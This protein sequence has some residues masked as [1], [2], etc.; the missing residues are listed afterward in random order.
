MPTYMDRKRYLVVMAAGHGTRMGAELPKQFLSLSGK[1]ILHRTIQKFINA[2]PGI[3]VVTVLPPDGEHVAW[4]KNYCRENNFICPQIIVKGGI[5]RFHSV[6]AA[7]EKVPDGALVAVQDGVRPMISEA[8]IKKMFGVFAENEDIH[9]L[10]PV[11]SMVD[12]LKL[13]RR[14]KDG[15]GNV[16]LSGLDGEVPDREKIFAAQTPQIFRSEELKAAYGQAY[17][18]AFTDDASV[19]AGYKIP[20][21]YCEGERLNFKITSPDDLV[22]AEAVLKIRSKVRG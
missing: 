7:L 16:L 4:W 6:R 20:L 22:L 19:A 13:L 21:T 9:A 18:T 5:T 3:N 2:V 15:N 11:T 14:T 17:D 10:I 1:A 12:T 8:L